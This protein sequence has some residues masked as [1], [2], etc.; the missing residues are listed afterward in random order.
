MIILKVL[1][2]VKNSIFKIIK[3]IFRPFSLIFRFFFLKI[4]VKIY[5]WFFKLKK[6]EFKGKN[7]SFIF[8][9]KA[10]HFLAILL[11]VSMLI[12]SL[13]ART[14]AGFNPERMRES[15]MAKAVISDLD[16]LGQEELVVETADEF[17]FK[18]S[19]QVINYLSDSQMKRPMNYLGMEEKTAKTLINGESDESLVLTRP[20]QIDLSYEEGISYETEAKTRTD[21]VEYEIQSGDT[22]SSIAQ[23][24][25][26][27]TNTIL[28]ANNLSSFSL[29]RPGDTLTI[30]PTDGVLHTVKSGENLSY[31][32]QRYSV[33]TQEISDYNNVRADSL[34][35]N[36]KLIIPGASRVKTPT[37]TTTPSPTPTPT[38]TPTPSPTPSPA[39]STP[40]KMVW[41]T[42]GHRITQYF[43]W[44]HKGLDVANKTGTPIYASEA[45]VVE[46][47]GWSTGYGNNILIDHGGGKK[48]RYA[49]MS[50]LFVSVGQSV[51]RGAHIA[52]MGS[53]GWSTGPHLHFEV[54]VNGSKQNPLNYI[55]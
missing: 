53:T 3:T 37:R 51:G 21:I 15:I 23:K 10:M 32:A 4:I 43:S 47:S 25:G 14:Q 7:L 2:L 20:Q 19:G 17:S 16:M 9:Q 12:F 50:R 34:S 36:Q 39:P 55:K 22:I 11:V 29:I 26:L 41:P 6:Y 48:T 44:R 24:F 38:P 42:E 33:A 1:I 30:L 46:Y 40:G 52:A 8:N 28:W 31:L 45:G 54:I 18:Q 49:H 13:G 27:R 35:I 5:Y